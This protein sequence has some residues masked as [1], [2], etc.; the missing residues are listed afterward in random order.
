MKN[1]QKLLKRCLP[2]VLSATVIL[3]SC[4]FSQKALAKA[5]PLLSA[6][7]QYDLVE[8]KNSWAYDPYIHFLY[9]YRDGP[10]NSNFMLPK[11]WKQIKDIVEY[12]Y[13]EEGVTSI[14][15]AFK[16]TSI[17]NVRIPST[18][19]Y[20]KMGAFE[21]CV[22]LNNID[23]G[24]KEHRLCIEAHAFRGAGTCLEPIEIHVPMQTQLLG[25]PQV[26]KEEGPNWKIVYGLEEKNCLAREE[27][28]DKIAQIYRGQ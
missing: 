14:G 2:S 13:I 9:I 5:G 26:S 8:S 28:N 7:R 23:F 15:C 24:L 3:G 16:G 25:P 11:K 18:V 19:T 1:L 6:M 12:V 22:N 4:L 17:R 27:M 20:I 10:L 21:D